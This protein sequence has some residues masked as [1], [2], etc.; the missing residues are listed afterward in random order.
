M[1]DMIGWIENTGVVPEGV[2]KDTVIE[3]FYRDTSLHLWGT[4]EVIN[5]DDTRLWVLLD[6]DFDVLWW[7]FVETKENNN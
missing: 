2:T 6:M 5:N 1:T 4:N 7:R 3:V